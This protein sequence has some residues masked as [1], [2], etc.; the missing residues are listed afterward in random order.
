MTQNLFDLVEFRWNMNKHCFVKTVT[1]KT[2]VPASIAYAEK[3]KI[4][5]YRGIISYPAPIRFKVVPNGEL[6]YSNKF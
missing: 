2:N 3:K 4:E 5:G 1:H 6:Q